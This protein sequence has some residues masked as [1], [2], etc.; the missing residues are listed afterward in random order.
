M[1]AEGALPDGLIET[2]LWTRADGYFLR[3]G[4]FDR[5]TNSAAALGFAFSATQWD[6]TLAQACADPPAANLRVRLIFAEM[7][8]SKAPR[9]PSRR[10]RREKSGGS[11]S[12]RLASTRAIRCCATRPR[13]ATSMKRRWRRRKAPTR[14]SSSMSATR[15]A[16]ARGPMFSSSATAPCRRRRFLRPASR[17]FARRFAWREGRRKKQFCGWTTCVENFSSAIPC[18]VFCARDSRWEGQSTPGSDG[19]DCSRLGTA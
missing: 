13:G 14:W 16:K 4:H 12:P 10:S 5:I 11:Q 7:A 1:S 2:F 3:D 17:R 18:A 8:R 15:S 9:R 6:A 19:V